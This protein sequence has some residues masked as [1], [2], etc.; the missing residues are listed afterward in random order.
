M[1]GRTPAISLY[2]AARSQRAIRK[3]SSKDGKVMDGK[4]IDNRGAD[5]QYSLKRLP[6][7]K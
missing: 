5:A 6:R 4:V 2:S 3:W 1:A 7:R